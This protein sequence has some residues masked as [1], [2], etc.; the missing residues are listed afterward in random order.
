[1]QITFEG[2]ILN[3]QLK[4]NAVLNA[5]AREA[6]RADYTKRFD[7]IM[8]REHGKMDYILYKDSKS[9]IFYAHIKVPSETV[10]KFYYDTVIKFF[11]DENVKNTEDLFKY[12]IQVFSNDPAF[13][14]TYAYVFKENDLFINSLAPKMARKAIKQSPNERNPYKQVGY[15]KS[16]YF[17][18]L[19][20][21]AKG[22]NKKSTFEADAKRFSLI[23]LMREIEKADKK[24][25]DREAEGAKLNKLK[26]AEKKKEQKETDNIKVANK[27]DKSLSVK[28]T[29]NAK[30]VKSTIK[31][32][33]KKWKI[34]YW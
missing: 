15:V 25:E 29:P 30:I 5:T 16:L 23:A 3:P 4:S 6:I 21:K 19:I 22:L 27:I 17:A 9:N 18:Y 8:L 24:I 34:Y 26:A 10:D 33:K 31:K 2:Y 20:M 12:N 11:A 13:V 1:M 14:Y 28:K 32:V 7:A